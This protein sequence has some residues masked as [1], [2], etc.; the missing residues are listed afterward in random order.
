MTSKMAATAAAAAGRYGKLWGRGHETLLERRILSVKGQGATTYLQGLLTCNLLQDPPIP[1]PEFNIV[2]GGGDEES[3]QDVKFSPHLR[4]T[5]FLDNKGRIVTDALL[6]KRG[7]EEEEHEY[8]IDVPSNVADQLLQHLNSFKMRRSKVTIRD[9]SDTISSHAVYGTLNAEGSPP[10]YLSAMDP[11]HPSLGMRVLNVGNDTEDAT[12]V[13]TKRKQFETLMSTHFPP[14]S[15]T[16][17]VIRKLAGVA[18]GQ[19][20][21]GRTALECNQ[22]FLNAVSFT[23]GCY[24][25]QE[26]TARTQFKGVIRKRI[27]PMLLVDT[28]TEIPRPWIL[29]SMIQDAYKAPDH[30]K[31]RPNMD[32]LKAELAKNPNA[33]PSD[34]DDDDDGQLEN[35]PLLPRISAPGAGGVVA[36]LM[37]SIMPLPLDD[38]AASPNTEVDEGLKVLQEQSE[39]LL[40]Q[41]EEAAVVGAKI[42]DQA[43]GKTIGQVVA[44]PAPGTTV[45]LAQLRLDRVGLMDTANKWSRTNRVLVGTSK[46][47][48]RY[49]PF[50]PLW[51]PRIDP[52]TGKEL[53]IQE[54]VDTESE[55]DDSYY[56]DDDGYEEESSDTDTNEPK[57]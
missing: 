2:P 44:P 10:G 31:K 54:E 30:K 35:L 6:W 19:E 22:E 53:V 18:E 23:K 1:R 17:E 42:V 52:T 20:I 33:H 9:K 48:L 37:G 14:A 50:L 55:T 13:E 51:W 56:E 25:G 49:L 32:K 34:N 5:C 38:A 26:L 36:M 28:D 16:N 21:M 4:A 43:D 41:V 7:V 47:E 3:S 45:M 46:K 24:L 8:L 29:A 12:S 27:M 11:R 40:E 15:G 57:K 39:T